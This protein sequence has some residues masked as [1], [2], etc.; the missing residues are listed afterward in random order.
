MKKEETRKLVSSPKAL[1]EYVEPHMSMVK[2][3]W[4]TL[5]FDGSCVG[6]MAACAE[7]D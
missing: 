4:L 5:L 7:D 3:K 2:L 1:K 6:D